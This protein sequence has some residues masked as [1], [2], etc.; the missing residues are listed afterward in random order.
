MQSPD[1]CKDL[2][3]E[4]Q[5]CLKFVLWLVTGMPRSCFGGEFSYLA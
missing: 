5:V 3:V 2:R 1:H 4:G